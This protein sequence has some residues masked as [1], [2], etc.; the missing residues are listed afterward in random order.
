MQERNG[1]R[2]KVCTSGISFGRRPGKLV[3]LGAA[4]AHLN[5]NILSENVKGGLG[6][7]YYIFNQFNHLKRS[8]F[9]SVEGLKILLS[10]IVFVQ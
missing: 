9:L 10:L 4:L 1:R 6:G 2:L 3:H 7:C 5:S 8:F